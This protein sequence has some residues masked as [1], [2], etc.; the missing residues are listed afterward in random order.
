MGENKARRLLLILLEKGEAEIVRE[1]RSG[2]KPAEYVRRA[3]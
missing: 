2:T 1:A 3:K